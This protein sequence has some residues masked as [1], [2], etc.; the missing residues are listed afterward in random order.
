MPASTP[1]FVVTKDAEVQRSIAKA[2]ES[3]TLFSHP[4]Y[5]AGLDELAVALEQSEVSVTVVD[6]NDCPSQVLAEI[7]PITERFPYTRLIVI[8]SEQRPEWI[9]Q[10]MQAGARHLLLKDAVATDL[11]GVLQRLNPSVPEPQGPD[12]PGPC[13]RRPSCARAP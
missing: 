3:T 1:L 9:I 8:A 5:C 7:E 6:M 2:V 11:L 13:R 12:M 10:A 4:R